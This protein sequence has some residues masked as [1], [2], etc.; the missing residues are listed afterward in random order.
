MHVAKH[1]RLP[2]NFTELQIEVPPQLATNIQ[3]FKVGIL[4]RSISFQN[5]SGVWRFQTSE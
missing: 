4:Y 1:S 3:G 5:I 2:K